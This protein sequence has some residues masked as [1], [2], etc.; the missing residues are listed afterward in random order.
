[1]DLCAKSSDANATPPAQDP[2]RF[3]GFPEPTTEKSVVLGKIMIQKEK[4][5]H[6]PPPLRA[7]QLVSWLLDFFFSSLTRVASRDTSLLQ[8]T[9]SRVG[10][11][12]RVTSHGHITEVKPS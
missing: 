8:S 6:P 2:T 5:I 10:V 9:L 11:E 1:M 3:P 7:A 12:S 4:K